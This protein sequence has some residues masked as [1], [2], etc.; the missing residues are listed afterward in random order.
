[1]VELRIVDVRVHESTRS[2]YVEVRP[3]DGT[4]RMLPIFVGMPEAAAIKRALEERLLP[5]PLTHELLASLIPT[6]GARLDQVVIT[7]FVDKIFHAEMHFSLGDRRE[8]VPCRP[9]DAMAIA[10][11]LGAKVFANDVV[12]DLCAVA[13]SDDPLADDTEQSDEKVDPDELVEEFNRFLDT[14]RPEDFGGE[15]P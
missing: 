3:L 6:F 14:L 11:R 2:P 12:L 9:S 15:T 4:D 5:R 13:D 1:M 7:E 10:L 8:T